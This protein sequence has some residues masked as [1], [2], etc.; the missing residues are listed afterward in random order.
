MNCYLEDLAILNALGA[1]KSAVLDRLLAGDQ[2]G[3]RAAGP[4][5]TG[6]H[7]V[8]GEVGDSLCEIPEQLQAF[9]CRNN[10][11][12][13]TAAAEFAGAIERLKSRFGAD[14]I[15]VLIGTSTSGISAGEEAF[16]M[17]AAGH[18]MPQGY[19]YRQ[20]EIGTAAEFLAR[21]LG[22]AGPRYTISTACSS[23]AKAIA[24]ARRLLAARICDAVVVGGSDSLCGL[25]TNGFDALEAMSGR[26]CNP[27]SANRDGINVGEG[28]ALFILTREEAP[29]R[30]AG[31]GESS[32][33]YHMTAPEPSGAGAE[34]AIR[35]ALSD[36]AVEPREIGYLNLHGTA[37]V[38]NDAVESR[39]V[40]RVF[41]LDTP[42]SSTKSQ[43]G[44]TLGAAGAQEVGLCW[45]LLSDSNDARRLPSHLWDGAVDP[46]LAA[47]GLTAGGARWEK[48][49]FM[50]NSFA[51]G[52][53]NIS[54]IIGRS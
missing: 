11:L 50:S 38:M 26:V 33:S 18:G 7:G 14:N 36:A 28:A 42:C 22:L 9:D 20:Q 15:G 32:D 17:L 35:A 12:L 46:D 13:A 5:L 25:T 40:E 4:L 54:V 52:G 21:F 3:M 2:T 49:L 44:H 47:I 19:H 37:T 30:V 24:A 48:D 23:S 8:V 31:I 43:T 53:S 41:G 1:G 27:F 10:R 51:F 34:L 29:T 45:L 39:V 6:R 16:S